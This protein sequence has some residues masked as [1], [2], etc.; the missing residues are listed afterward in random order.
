MDADRTHNPL[1]IKKLLTG[2]KRIRQIS[3]LPQ[4]L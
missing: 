2:S 3:L 4:D 1:E